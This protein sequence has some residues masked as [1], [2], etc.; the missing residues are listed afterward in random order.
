[1]GDYILYQPLT[2]NDRI[3][4]M[5]YRAGI[6]LTCILFAAMAVF[7]ADSAA[8]A[9][10]TAALLF[11]IFLSLLYCA[12]GL[13]VFCIHLYIRKLKTNLIWLYN[14]ALAGLILFVIISKGD[15]LSY[16][17]APGFHLGPILMLPLAGCIG[18]IAAKEAVCFRLVEGY[19]LAMLMPL[20]LVLLAGGIMGKAAIVSGLVV[21]AALY[22]LF[23]L[24]KIFMPI[25]SDIGDKSAYR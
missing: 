10:P 17:I 11:N 25:H 1:M 21:I 6:A 2:R 16:F 13:S 5:L 23:T 4:V 18:F 3:T 19:L 24:R 8:I 7:F 12:T 15:C 14:L 20:Y 22:L 9:P